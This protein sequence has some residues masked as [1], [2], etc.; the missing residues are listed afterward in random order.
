MSRIIIFLLAL[1]SVAATAAGAETDFTIQGPHGKLAARLQ[2]PENSDKGDKLPLVI[3][4]HGF[5]GNS[6]GEL[7]DDLTADLTADGI[8]VLR[9]DFNGHG[10]SE[11][12]FQNMTV[13]NEIQDLRS[14]IAWAR[15][16]KWVK[17]ISLL[18][19][20]Q[21]GVVAGMTA[22]E[23]GRDSIQCLV[24]MAPA[25]VLRDD[26]LRGNTMGAMYD[27][28]NMKEDY[29]ALW[30]GNLK[31]GRAYIES[32]ISLP[33]YETSLRYTGPVLIVHGTHDRVVPYTYGDRYDRG[34]A[35]SRLILLDGDDHGFTLNTLAT[36]RAV[37]S[38]LKKEL[39][40]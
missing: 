26:A 20:S 36:A 32:A 29:V 24:L 14:V 25:A 4:C 6:G 35:D 8:A 5:A 31:L 12:E 39:I 11:G 21:G 40:H 18:G 33:I 2:M 27:P 23:L 10:R 34:Y 28:W 19:H 7:F 9:F 37:A 16:R 30:G 13:P 15:A 38:W 17:N 1:L 3:L 22:G